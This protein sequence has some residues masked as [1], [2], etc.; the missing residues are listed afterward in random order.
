MDIKKFAPWNWFQKESKDEG[1]TVPVKLNRMNF[2][3]DKE[4]RRYPAPSSHG[5]GL[6]M[7]S[8][9]DDFFKDF[10]LFSSAHRS[11]LE[12]MT[13][14][15]LKPRL[16]LGAT[17][18]EY[19]VSIEIPG[20]GGKDVS[21]E[22]IDDTLIVR[23]EKKQEKEEKK[24]NFYRVERSYGAF[25]RTLSLPEDA[26]RKNIKADFKNGVLNITIPRMA[27]PGTAPRQ[28]EIKCA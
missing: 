18:K 2:N 19:T 9:F 11:L 17:D 1:H 3:R 5:M 24:K 13:G 22:L 14:N 10:G 15:V 23:G 20:V 28:I 12:Q 27:V 6:E 4:H 7:D 25:Q 8:L 26:D 16:D 21:L